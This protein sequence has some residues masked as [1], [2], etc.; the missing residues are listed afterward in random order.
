MMMAGHV[1]ENGWGS[2]KHRMYRVFVSVSENSYLTAGRIKIQS[3]GLRVVC[4]CGSVAAFAGPVGM[5][6]L[7]ARCVQAF[8]SV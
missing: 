3:I 5:E 2:F 4:G 1:P 6:E 8:I 7:V